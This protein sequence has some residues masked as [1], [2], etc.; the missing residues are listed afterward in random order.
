M[1]MLPEEVYIWEVGV[2]CLSGVPSRKGAEEGIGEQTRRLL[3]RH[4][5]G[6]IHASFQERYWLEEE[7]RHS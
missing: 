1:N 2:L 4:G 6:V 3:L 7:R 5:D